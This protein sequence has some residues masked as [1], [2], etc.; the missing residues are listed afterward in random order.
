MKVRAADIKRLAQELGFAACGMSRAEPVGAEAASALDGW[1]EQGCHAGMGYMQAHRELRK[2]PRGLLE[3]AKTVLSVALNYYPEVRR[4]PAGP[5]IAYYAYGADYHTVMKAKLG[6]LWAGIRA[7]L[8]EGAD[9]V[10]ARLF[11]DSAPLLERYWAWRSGLGWQGKHTNLIIP[12]A[13]SFFFLGEIVTTLEADVY[14][15]PLR[16]RCG[17]CRRCLDACPTGALRRPYCLD[18][19]RCIS[20]LTIEHRGEIPAELAPRMQGMLFGCDAC[21]QACPWNR[22]ARPTAEEAFR[23]SE[24]LLHLRREALCRMT[25]EDYRRLFK[26][27]AVKRAK[28]SGLLRTI[29]SCFRR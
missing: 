21:Q 12:R 6:Q 14:D 11:T 13:G 10:S 25:E 7:L 23:P 18:A 3:G 5:Y 9:G 20:Y 15:K 22:F 24:E 2:D 27:S 29:R 17:T 19:N 8:P 16:P 26:G 4:D 28:F 1:L